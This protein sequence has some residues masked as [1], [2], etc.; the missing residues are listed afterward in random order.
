M[1][2]SETTWQKGKSGN[3]RGRPKK[4]RAL[5]ALLEK[6]GGKRLP[7]STEVARTAFARH[8][9]EGLTC[10][11]IKFDDGRVIG[12]D[13]SDYISLAKMVLTQI[14]GA[15]KEAIDIT[16][17]GNPVGVSLVEVVKSYD[18]AN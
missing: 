12:L 9:W 10:G 16:T 18:S 15:P 4:S 17:D 5:T 3:P 2:T 11:Q 7:D 14:D 13:A 6:Y 8:V 1:A